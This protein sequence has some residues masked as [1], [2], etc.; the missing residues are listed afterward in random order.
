MGGVFQIRETAGPTRRQNDGATG[1]RW[2]AQDGA[3]QALLYQR[4]PK[5]K[6]RRESAS[7][8]DAE[9]AQP[10]TRPAIK[11]LDMRNIVGADMG[12]RGMNSIYGILFHF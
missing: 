10:G 7:P 1:P 6:G 5:K 9:V 3:L 12:E 11:R 2:Q 8:H 4:A